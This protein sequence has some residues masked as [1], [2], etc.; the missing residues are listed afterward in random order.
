MASAAPVV[1]VSAGVLWPLPRSRATAGLARSSMP[2]AAGMMRARTA[3]SPPRH[4]VQEGRRSG[5]STT[6][7]PGPGV[8]TDMTVTAM[9]P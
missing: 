5:R 2:T 8:T 9:M 6:A 4:A 1:A 3:R 7:R